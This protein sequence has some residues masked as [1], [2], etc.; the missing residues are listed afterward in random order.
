MTKYI[1]TFA[2]S[3]NVGIGQF[4][5]GGYSSYRL[6]DN[7]EAMEDFIVD[8]ELKDIRV[9]KIEK[10]FKLKRDKIALKEV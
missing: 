2:Q 9:Y 3:S 1:V 8:V 7:K 6:F 4:L 5:Q 10:E